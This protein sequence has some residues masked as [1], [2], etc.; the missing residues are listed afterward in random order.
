MRNGGYFIQIVDDEIVHYD[1]ISDLVI[2]KKI[3]T[4]ESY[5]CVICYKTANIVTECC[6]YYCTEC[7]ETHI[8]INNR[9][10]PYCRAYMCDNKM[11]KLI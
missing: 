11:A 2:N 7:L 1:I 6:H 9:K 5:E 8:N 3:Q 4:S 10:C